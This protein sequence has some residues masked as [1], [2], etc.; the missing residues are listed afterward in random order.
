MVRIFSKSTALKAVLFFFMAG[1]SVEG[2]PEKVVGGLLHK[3]I[4]IGSIIEAF[5]K[6][7][8]KVIVPNKGALES[9]KNQKATIILP[10][11]LRNMEQNAELWDQIFQNILS[12]YGYTIIKKG[13]I[14]RLVPSGDIKKMP[15]PII[16]EEGYPLSDKSE[17]IVT[18]VI[19]LKFVQHSAIGPFAAF[20]SANGGAFLPLQDKERKTIIVTASESDL[21]YFLSL[22]SIF[23]VPDETVF[24]FKVYSLKRAVPSQ[25]KAQVESYLAT[26]SQRDGAP[27][28]PTEKPYIAL[29]DSTNR[30]LVSATPEDHKSIEKLIEFF[31]ADI[32]QTQVFKPIEIYR[33]KNSNAESV[34]KKLDQVLKSKASTT[35]KDPNKKEDIPTIVPFEELNALI[36]SV[37]EPDTFRYIKDVID[38]LD[39]KRNQVYIASTIVEVNK[40]NGFNFGLTFGAGS[41]PGGKGQFGIIGGGDVGGAGTITYDTTGTVLSRGATV[42]P[43]VGSGLSLA[44]PYGGM[45]FIPVVM[46][47]AE[48]DSDISVLANPSIICDDNEHAVIEITEQRQ[49]NTTTYNGSTTSNTSFGG[50]NDAGIVLDIKPTISSDSFLKLELTQNVDRFLSDPG[51]DQIRNKRK[52][53]T[54]VTIPNKTS[55]VIGGLTESNLNKSKSML[56]FL[57][58]IPLLGELF[59][60]R[61]NSNSEKTL[62]FFITPEI[63]TN[64]E[65]LAK[66]SD[67]HH[68]RMGKVST[69]ETRD[70]QIFKDARN[71]KTKYGVQG[72]AQE[73]KTLDLL[74]SVFTRRSLSKWIKTGQAKPLSFA[75][76][77]HRTTSP[78]LLPEY[79]RAYFDEDKLDSNFQDTLLAANA[80]LEKVSPEERI[81]TQ[82]AFNQY[83]IKELQNTNDE[84]GRRDQVDGE[85]PLDNI[86]LKSEQ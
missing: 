50:F 59:K 58:K 30:L 28:P 5:S 55:V 3:E 52:A 77:E 31:D 1:A 72:A 62:Y 10:S 53:T 4:E 83:L 74:K 46:K 63:I 36:I 57:S 35:T 66:I 69:Q 7:T 84:P 27:K 26:T 61:N 73:N 79:T 49:F 39:V 6:Q 34:A 9:V 68:D 54:V 70:N 43:T 24:T 56:P 2:A 12:I 8:G 22:V 18:Q 48:T 71:D 15:V 13:D 81:E 85:N 64:F 32:K 65:E 23:D 14:Y 40:A 29:D 60:S 37:E 42:A 51:Q 44:F 80:Q 75:I 76:I 41:A 20:I 38:M 82:T 67:R 78:G 11:D 45:D 47:A 16:D 33:L 21:K 19:R 86:L 25:I 17:R